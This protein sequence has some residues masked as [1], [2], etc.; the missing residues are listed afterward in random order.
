MIGA[1]I[2]L[3]GTSL[4]AQ[5]V[6]HLPTMRETQVQSLGWEDLLEKEMATHSSILA[7][8][9]PS[10][11]ELGGLQSMRSQKVRHG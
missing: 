10:T 1:C 6:K 3:I 5:M 2:L 7:W 8:K 11:E 9:N 4:V